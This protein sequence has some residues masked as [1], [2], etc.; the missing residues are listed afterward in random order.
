MVEVRGTITQFYE[1]C[2]HQFRLDSNLKDNIKGS[3]IQ[4]FYQLIQNHL[5]YQNY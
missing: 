2:R 5:K 4:N 3:T 1:K